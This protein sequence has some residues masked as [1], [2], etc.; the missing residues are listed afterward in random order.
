ML[1]FILDHPFAYGFVIGF[2]VAIVYLG[3]KYWTYLRSEGGDGE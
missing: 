1:K 2:I 3:F